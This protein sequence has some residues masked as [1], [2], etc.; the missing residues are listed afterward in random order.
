[1]L[2]ILAGVL[3][4]WVLFIL[5]AAVMNLKRARD[6]GKM[7]VPM[8]ILGTPVLFIGLLLDALVNIFVFTLILLELPQEFLVTSRL[9]R[10]IK[11]TGWRARVAKWFC[12]NLLDSLDPSGCHCK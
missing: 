3:S 8:N 2:I 9:S 11:K 1:M 4:L 12:T 7:T 10:H 6:E 5:Y